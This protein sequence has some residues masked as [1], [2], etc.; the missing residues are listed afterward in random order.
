[1]GLGRKCGVTFMTKVAFQNGPECVLVTKR[2]TIIT[3]TQQLGNMHYNERQHHS[4]IK[5]SLIK[6]PLSSA[7][8]W[9]WQNN[10]IFGTS[11]TTHTVLRTC[12]IT[13][14]KTPISNNRT[15]IKEIR[16]VIGNA[17]CQKDAPCHEWPSYL[18]KC[19]VNMMVFVS[20]S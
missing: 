20:W 3:F 1:M 7:H 14:I 12:Y 8:I 2:G 13:S 9:Q 11:Q 17:G 6:C 16:V 15:K 18:Q 4:N 19:I 5:Y 10:H